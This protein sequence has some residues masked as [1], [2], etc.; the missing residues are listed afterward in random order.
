M[1]GLVVAAAGSG[2]GKTSVTCGLAR[3]LSRRGVAVRT[4]KCGPDFLDPLWLA[5]ASGKACRNLDP[6]M[7]SPGYIRSLARQSEEA[8]EFLLVE[9]VMGL[10]DSV[11]PRSD[12]GSTFDVARILDLPVLLVLDARAQARTFAAVVQGLRDFGPAPIVGV[13]ANRVGSDHHGRILS[14]ALGSR[15]LPPLVGWIAEGELPSL[16]ERHLGLA[17]ESIPESLL[18]VLADAIEERIGLAWADIP[19]SA[20]DRSAPS[21]APLP[22]SV[23]MAVSMDEAFLFRYPDQM[24]ALEAAGVELVPTSPI[25]DGALPRGIHGL[26]LCGGYPELHAQRI[27]RNA[28]YL[29]DL[30][31][32]CDGNRPVLAECGG[33]MLLSRS[34]VD[35]QGQEHGMADVLGSRSRMG[36]RL[37]A[38]GH[39][40]V[41]VAGDF[42][43]SGAGALRG[44]EFH[45]GTLEAP[46]R[47]WDPLFDRA[48]ARGKASGD[49][50]RRGKVA[51]TW[52]H[53]HLASRPEAIRSW[54]R[55]MQEVEPWN[56]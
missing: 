20:A 11:D 9:G 23:R 31:N 39:V 54:V 53:L 56:A 52:M 40:E 48:T 1:K 16:P 26:W 50:W 10:Y 38:L 55:A 4:A 6:W 33:M 7:M 3:S 42:W 44:H 14:Q 30:R 22:G 41:D 28:T 47:G 34:I 17:T 43:L 13:V 15:G 46:P 27:S 37:S 24:E 21:V 19:S 5:K 25:R 18:D 2:S 12:E 45:W 35:A 8:G 49:G 51:A 36:A 29:E 32:F